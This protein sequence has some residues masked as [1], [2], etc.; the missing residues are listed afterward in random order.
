MPDLREPLGDRA[1]ATSRRRRLS[2]LRARTLV[3][4]PN[5][6]PRHHRRC[7]H[8]Q[9]RDQSGHRTSQP[10]VH[11]PRQPAKGDLEPVGRPACQQFVYRRPD[12][13][14]Q[15]DERRQRQTGPVRIDARGPR[16]TDRGQAG[17]N[18]H[19][20]REGKR[21]DGIFL[22][23]GARLER[24]RRSTWAERAYVSR[25]R[26]RVA[27]VTRHLPWPPAGCSSIRASESARCGRNRN[28]L[29]SGLPPHLPC[30]STWPS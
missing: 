3:Q 11:F 21:R 7:H 9:G 2:Q 24:A 12:C 1:L 20:R 17:P 19:P 22:A 15:A 29:A 16:D 14:E 27:G 10:G 26:C 25:P 30:V 28:R 6:R 8:W 23:P 13:L 5:R 18:P 4:R